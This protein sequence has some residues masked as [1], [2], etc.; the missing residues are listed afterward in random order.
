M[1]AHQKIVP[2]SAAILLVTVLFA[3]V[4]T[5][6]AAS[7]PLTVSASSTRQPTQLSLSASSIIPTAGRAVTFSGTLKTTR[8]PNPLAKA[9]IYLYV[10]KDNKN[11][12]LVYAPSKTLTNVNG[13]YTFSKGISIGTWY[14]RTYFDP[15]TTQYS[16]AYSPTVKVV[17]R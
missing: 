7:T 1:R 6:S 11:W 2:V 4:V 17:A 13:A 15:G 10:S 8:T 14:F 3:G 9:S 16:R 12:S 5:V